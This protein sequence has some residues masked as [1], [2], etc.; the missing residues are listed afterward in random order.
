MLD[1]GQRGLNTKRPTIVFFFGPTK[2]LLL[3]DWASL[4]RRYSV[5]YEYREMAGR[6]QT[7]PWWRGGEGG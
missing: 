2:P 3:Y 5:S 1:Q 7:L 4:H 6:S